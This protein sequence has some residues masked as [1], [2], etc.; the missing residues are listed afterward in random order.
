MRTS[1]R[2]VMLRRARSARTRFAIAGSSVMTP[3]TPRLIM[4]DIVVGSFTVHT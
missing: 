2:S 4:L 3:S 1:S